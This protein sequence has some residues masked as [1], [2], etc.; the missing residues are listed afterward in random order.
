MRKRYEVGI[1]LAGILSLIFGQK[2]WAGTYV[3]QEGK[4]R[5]QTE[6]ETVET[7]WIQE[8]GNWYCLD[9]QGQR[10]SGW[11]FEMADGNWYYLEEDGA[12]AV[13]WKQFEGKWFWL[14]PVS[15]GSKGRSAAGWQ[16]LDGNGD[17]MAECYYFNP[18]SIPAGE[19]ASS[20]T[21]P[22]GFQVDEN[23]A[24]IMEGKIVQKPVSI[25]PEANGQRSGK[26]SQKTADT[27]RESLENEEKPK[28][29]DSGDV[30][31]IWGE[32]EAAP[33][34]P[35]YIRN[36]DTDSREELRQ[37]GI[38]DN[39]IICAV[40]GEMSVKRDD[41]NHREQ[42]IYDLALEF[43]RQH[44]GKSE[45]ELVT[46]ILR[47]LWTQSIYGGGKAENAFSPYGVLCQGKGVCQ[48]YARSFKILANCCGLDCF[49]AD[50]VNMNHAWNKVKVDGQ[51][52]NI[53]STRALGEIPEE[54]IY[55]ALQ[56]DWEM[57]R[58][59]A[60]QTGEYP[61]CTA[62]TWAGSALKKTQWEKEKEMEQENFTQW[63]ET[64]I[65]PWLINEEEN[66]FNL[67]ESGTVKNPGKTVLKA[68][69][70]LGSRLEERK[71]QELA[72]I[73]QVDEGQW[74][75]AAPDWGETCLR[76]LQSGGAQI[77]QRKDTPLKFQYQPLYGNYEAESYY[78]IFIYD[79]I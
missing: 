71:I 11:H 44:Q 73:F 38:D 20:Q 62:L 10:I 61:D 8:G 2:V 77:R 74:L 5:F 76:S 35:F 56:T 13:G 3:Y 66:C 75:N 7:G 72:I 26:D 50:S 41:L 12:L 58:Y 15:D 36:K 70:S 42:D 54:E 25:S 32:K 51:W 67:T 18:F 52:Y 49:Y 6:E 55:Y 47:Y 1:M 17:G 33:N 48:S 39:K 64:Y 21:T 68:V 45:Y 30:W 34:N 4:W 14:N 63:K 46:E 24:W 23:G 9:S 19:M 57:C 65:A 29:K 60:S 22:D 59:T 40:L 69:E 28:E 37:Y 43:S 53:N 27:G 79:K 31:E 78:L 16:W